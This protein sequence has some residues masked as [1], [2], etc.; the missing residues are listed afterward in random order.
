M[1]KTLDRIVAIAAKIVDKDVL[2]TEA[3][4]FKEMQFDSLD[5]IDFVVAIEDEFDIVIGIADSVN[6]LTLVDVAEVVE[7]RCP[8]LSLAA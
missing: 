1:T 2:V 4:S 5:C 7:A 8:G 3:S 6:F